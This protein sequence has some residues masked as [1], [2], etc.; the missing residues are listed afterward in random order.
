M[1]G[2]YGEQHRIAVV[3]GC[4]CEWQLHYRQVEGCNW[5]VCPVQKPQVGQYEEHWVLPVIETADEFI[6]LASSDSDEERRRAALEDAPLDVWMNLVTR[7]P[8]YRFAVA[9]NKTIPD[10]ILHLLARDSDWRVR[11]GVASKRRC[12]PDIL[13]LLAADENESISSTVASHPNTPPEALLALVN[14]PWEAIRE[15]VARR[16]EGQ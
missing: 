5:H 6:Q 11:Q 3:C 15:K 1:E 9:Y 4:R 13:A 14:H 7:H 16:I 10:E 2:I 8:E 12:P